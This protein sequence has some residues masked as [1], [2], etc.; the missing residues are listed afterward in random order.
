M[1]PGTTIQGGYPGIGM[2]MTPTYAGAPTY[3]PQ[4]V[5]RISSP[6]TQASYPSDSNLP[7]GA[8]YV[9]PDEYVAAPQRKSPAPAAPEPAVTE[10]EAGPG[11]K[12]FYKAAHSLTAQ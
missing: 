2:P 9:S 11:A 5:Q 6:A 12:A 4:A 7:A 10:P 3:A 1:M 8:R